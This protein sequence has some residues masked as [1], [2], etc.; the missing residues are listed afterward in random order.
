MASSP[1][2]S[3]GSGAQ[4]LDRID[5]IWPVKGSRTTSLKLHQPSRNPIG[6]SGAMSFF[7]E[8]K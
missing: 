8:F 7:P 6:A 4:W 3:I 1:R 2:P 5:I